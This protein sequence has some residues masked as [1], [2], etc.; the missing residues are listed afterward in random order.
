M[1]HQGGSESRLVFKTDGEFALI[2]LRDTV[3]RFQRGVIV[4]EL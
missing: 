1:G 3:G 4:P 2:C